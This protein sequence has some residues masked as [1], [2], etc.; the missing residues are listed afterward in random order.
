MK[1]KI[2]FCLF[3]SIVA[4]GFLFIPE[5]NS[6]SL[7][8]DEQ[9]IRVGTGAFQDGLYDIA[10]R[11]F[12]NFISNYPKHAR[13]FDIYYLLG[14]TLV[15]KGKLREARTVFSKIINEA[16]SFENMDD[17]LLGM[18]ELE[19]RL[20]NRDEAAKLL[21]T[22]IKKYPNFD[23]IDHAYYLLGLLELGSNQLTAAGSTG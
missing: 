15:I 22:V 9:L 5:S 23:Q 17:A 8:E 16:K 2:T 3:L 19:M 10:E 6:K 7:K 21:L 13:V 12:T 11:Q 14:R 1:Q 20:G 18:A 4:W